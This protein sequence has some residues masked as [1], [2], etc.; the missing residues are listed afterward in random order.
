MEWYPM[1]NPSYENS[2][3]TLV[4]SLNHILFTLDDSGKITCI[5]N[6]CSDHLGLLPE[7]MT[8][9]LMSVFVPSEHKDAIRE[10]C[11]PAGPGKTHPL[12]FPV[13][14]KNGVFHQAIAIS[15]SIFEGPGQTGMIGIIDGISTLKPDEKIIRQAN[16]RIHLLNS[17]V[18]H[19]INNQL[20]ILH[21]YLSLMGQ[22]ENPIRYPDIVMILQ[23]STEKI[24]NLVTFM[25]EYKDIGTHLPVWMNLNDAFESA[26][27]AFDVPGVQ[28]ASG[29]ACRDLELLTIPEF[30]KIFHHL[31]DNSLRHGKTV[32]EIYLHCRVENREAI[33]VYEDNGNGIED[34]LKS[35]LFQPGNRQMAG[36]G[37]LLVQEV[38][39]I[40]GFTITVTSTPGKGVRFEIVVP[41]GLFRVVK[42]N[43]Q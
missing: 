42:K 7:E 15:R 20:T 33:L 27:S 16:T 34:S 28:I 43:L 19:D 5:S 14:G 10:M 24:H 8:G 35:R 13:V 4:E 23:D 30:T 6:G 12:S 32:S 29:P 1:I 37:L 18:R 22:N 26:R 2:C 38:L 40:H 36:Y 25:A 41:E 9:R 39:A 3:R 17:I 21:G 11:G 31:I